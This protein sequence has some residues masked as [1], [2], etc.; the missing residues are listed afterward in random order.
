MAKQRRGR[1]GSEAGGGGGKAVLALLV[2]AAVA[3]GGFLPYRHTAAYQGTMNRDLSTHAAG[4]AAGDV[5]SQKEMS[6]GEPAKA[7]RAEKG[8]ALQPAPIGRV[9]GVK[10]PLPEAPFGESEEVFET[11]AMVYVAHCASCHGRPGHAAAAAVQLWSPHAAVVEQV[12]Q[13][14][15]GA[16][17][18]QIAEGVAAADGMPAMAGYRHVLSDTEIWDVALLLRNGRQELPDPVVHLL[19]G[20]SR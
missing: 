12:A 9:A 14:P 11:G 18:E 20:A 19:H 6:P 16:I 17:H 15:A 8:P 3:V 10:R 5:G 7:D 1:Q 4:Q 13:Q 2:L